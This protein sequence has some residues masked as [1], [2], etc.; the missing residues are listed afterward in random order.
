MA[1][2]SHFGPTVLVVSIT[3]I[4]SVTQ[5]TEIKSLWI[6]IAIFAGQR[7]VVWN[8]HLIDQPLDAT[9]GRQKKPLATRRVTRK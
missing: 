2:A 3:F 6:A 8:Y 4:L 7:V 5:L 1:S 9:A